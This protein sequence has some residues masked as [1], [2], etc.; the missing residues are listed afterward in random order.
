MSETIHPHELDDCITAS[1]MTTNLL[2]FSALNCVLMSE[3]SHSSTQKQSHTSARKDGTPF[4]LALL[5]THETF[6]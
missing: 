3:S 6:F 5:L 4:A 1:E 2:L